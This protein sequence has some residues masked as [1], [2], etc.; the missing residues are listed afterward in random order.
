[1]L[2]YLILPSFSAAPLCHYTQWS[3]GTQP[4]SPYSR[5][6]KPRRK[7]LIL[8]ELAWILTTGLLHVVLRGLIGM[9]KVS[10]RRAVQ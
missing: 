5:S 4:Y 3:T 10:K 2:I 7:T 6:V 1:M 8:G 9:M